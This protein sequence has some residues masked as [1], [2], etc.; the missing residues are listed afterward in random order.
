[1]DRIIE[2]F[3][4][5][6]LLYETGSTLLMVIIP[7]IIAYI[8]GIPLGFICVITSEKGIKPNKAVNKIL[9]LIINFGR[10]IPFIILICLLVPF[11]RFIVGTSLGPKGAMVPLTIACIPFVAR[12]VEQS[13]EEVDKGVIEAAICMGATIPQICTKIYLVESLPSLI[14]GLSITAI[15]LLGYTAMAG[16]VGA[17][18]LGYIAITHGYQRNNMLLMYICVVIIIVLVE[19]IQVALELLARKINKKN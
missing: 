11:T 17:K 1:M 16:A 15:T 12:M 9:S 3:K 18:G 5:Y 14:R 10:S 8:I 2:L 7:L 6:E 19:I 4:E 13:L